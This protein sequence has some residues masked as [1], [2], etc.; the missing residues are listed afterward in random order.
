MNEYT[1][2]LQHLAIALG[3]EVGFAGTADIPKIKTAFQ[4]IERPEVVKFLD[5]GCGLGVPLW[6]AK[7]TWGGNHDNGDVYFGI[8][9]HPK[10]VDVC[11]KMHS[12]FRVIEGDFT[13]KADMIA[14][15][16]IVF[17]YEPFANF[18]PDW[19]L[20]R[21]TAGTFFYMNGSGDITTLTK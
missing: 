21:M 19:V 2:Y 14:E 3:S 12:A 1:E 18:K 10:A 15:A 9:Q 16:N 13:E 8:D 17:T 20:E 7:Q 6:I 5:L 11:K 4:S